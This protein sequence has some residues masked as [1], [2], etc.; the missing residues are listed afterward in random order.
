M[1]QPS[2]KLYPV[3]MFTQSAVDA[4]LVSQG[5]IADSVQRVLHNPRKYSKGLQ[6]YLLV[7]G[8]YS[9]MYYTSLPSRSED[10]AYIQV[11]H[12]LQKDG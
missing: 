1:Y 8:S 10:P 7:A 11:S 6:Q 4:V 5:V 3:F 9:L 2:P 12:C